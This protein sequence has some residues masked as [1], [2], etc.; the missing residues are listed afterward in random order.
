MSTIIYYCAIQSIKKYKNKH[1]KNYIH[2]LYVLLFSANDLYIYIY[3]I[4][5]IYICNYI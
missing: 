2:V 1:F 5:Y 4:I 3:I